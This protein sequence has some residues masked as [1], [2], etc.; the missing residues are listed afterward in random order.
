MAQLLLA[1]DVVRLEGMFTTVEEK[2]VEE[3]QVRQRPLP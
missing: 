1:L 3:K 2:T